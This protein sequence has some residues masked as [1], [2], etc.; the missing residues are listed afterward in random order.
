M[1]EDVSAHI[2]SNSGGA[3]T[4]AGVMDIAFVNHA[5]RVIPAGTSRSTCQA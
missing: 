5:M 4:A 1:N 2:G 3:S